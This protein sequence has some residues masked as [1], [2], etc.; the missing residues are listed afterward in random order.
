MIDFAMQ[1]RLGAKVARF[2]RLDRDGL[3]AVLSKKIKP[4]YPFASCNG[5]PQEQLRDQVIDEVVAT[6]FSPTNETSP[7]S[8]DRLARRVV[9]NHVLLGRRIRASSGVRTSSGFPER[10]QRVK[11]NVGVPN[12][13]ILQ[14][15]RPPLSG[16]RA[17]SI[18]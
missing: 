7:N 9:G 18:V 6:L 14:S 8:T 12:R 10:R 15:R 11:K 3:A 4:H 5:T 2:K 16:D 17:I 1:R 13:L